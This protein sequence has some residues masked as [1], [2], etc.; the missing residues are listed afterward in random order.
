MVKPFGSWGSAPDPTRG[1]YSAIFHNSL[2]RFIQ[3]IDIMIAFSYVKQLLQIKC[4]WYSVEN[5][6]QKHLENSK[7][8]LENSWNFFHPKE[9]E[10]WL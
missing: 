3:S 10:P 7:I 2:C 9:W 4:V 1:A 8:V 6:D 5:Y